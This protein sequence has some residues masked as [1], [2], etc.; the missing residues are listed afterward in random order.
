MNQGFIYILINEAMPGIVKVG[1]TKGEPTNRANQLSSATGVPEKFSIF[2]EYAVVDCNEAE[3][4]AHRILERVFGRPN[5]KR[6]FFLGASTEV[7]ALLDE[8]LQPYLIRD[9]QFIKNNSFVGPMLKLERKEFTFAKIEFEEVFKSLPPTKENILSNSSLQKAAGAYLA[10]CFA[11]N[12][13]PIF[14]EIISPSVKSGVMTV[15]I[16][17]AKAFDSD[18]VMPLIEFVRRCERNL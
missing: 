4:F 1:R 12:T 11:I 8:A 7:A 14:H 17:F 10:C 15:A 2:R 3:S 18:P 13:P 16:D 6:E 9:D 5:S